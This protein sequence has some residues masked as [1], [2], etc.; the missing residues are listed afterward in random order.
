M[1][2]NTALRLVADSVRDMEAE[3]EKAKNGG[4]NSDW[5][6]TEGGF[7][8]NIKSR[9]LR[10]APDTVANPVLE[11]TDLESYKEMV[12]DEPDKIVCVR[13]YAPWCR[14]CRAVAGKFRKL[15]RDNRGVKFVE[16]PLTKE[17]AYLHQGLGV[18]SLPF[19][20]VYSPK[21]GLVEERSINKKEF[22]SFQRTLETY[23]D[24][25]CEVWYDDTGFVDGSSMAG[26]STTE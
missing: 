4:D 18:P 14:A 7:I 5:I 26:H 1:P 13:F 21:S 3:D 23:V 24:G 2:A 25:E 20:H 6:P 22:S 12:I 15:A 19:A 16:V 11:V 10:D 8:P 9:F 17:N